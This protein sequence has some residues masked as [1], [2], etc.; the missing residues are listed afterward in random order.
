[1]RLLLR[2]PGLLLVLVHRG[3]ERVGG[4]LGL[5][6]LVVAV[7][8]P[9]ELGLV[10]G[11]GRPVVVVGHL[12]AGLGQV[13]VGRPGPAAARGRRAGGR[14]LRA[15]GDPAVIAGAVVVVAVLDAFLSGWGDGPASSGG[16]RL[17]VG[18]PVVGIG[19]VGPHAQDHQDHHEDD[20]H[21]EA[22][23]DDVHHHCVT[24]QCHG[25][26]RIAGVACRDGL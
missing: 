20:D 25:P 3:A 1:V 24:I 23:D 16:G 18:H 11:D 2:L 22:G 21:D 9:G 13:V 8:L 5:R 7:V 17:I 19:P 6:A 4:Q 12:V 10:E 26:A 14:C 15:T